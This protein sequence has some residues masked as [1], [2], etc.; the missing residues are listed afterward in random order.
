MK[1][2]MRFLRATFLYLLLFFGFCA[3]TWAEEFIGKITT[4]LDGDTVLVVR[5]S[6][7]HALLTVRLAEIDAPEKDQE[8]GMAS[9][10]SLIDMVLNKQVRVTTQ[11]V[12]NYGRLIGIVTLG[13]LN[14]NH[15]QV[16]RGMAWENSRFHNNKP[17]LVLQQ[18]AQQN[19]RGLWAGADPIA[20]NIWRK[21][22]APLSAQPVIQTPPVAQSQPAIPHQTV[23]KSD[24]D[25]RSC[26]QMKSCDEAKL[27]FARCTAN[28]LDGDRD[29][30]PCENLCAAEKSKKH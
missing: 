25:K 7:Q 3:P 4:V 22:H 2:T 30:A 5:E 18:E 20:P 24:C 13:E 26:A 28:A 21:N 27:Y 8:Y 9:R 6:G 11:A 23:K 10:Q 15:A 29:G 17:V 16:Q 14:V 1:N 12:D 19:R